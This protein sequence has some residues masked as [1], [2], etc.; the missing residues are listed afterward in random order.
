VSRVVRSAVELRGSGGWVS[1]KCP[2][3]TVPL[4]GGA[5]TNNPAY[6][7]SENGPGADGQSWMVS[8]AP[9]TQT[10]DATVGA[11]AVCGQAPG[12]EIVRAPQKA[13][14]TCPLGK[15]AIGGGGRF[16][17][18]TG[19]Y[20]HA[21][22]SSW[23]M[24]GGQGVAEAT[25]VICTTYPFVSVSTATAKRGAGL[26]Q[27][28][29]PTATCPAGQVLIGGGAST[30]DVGY[31]A[32]SGSAPGDGNVFNPGDN[33]QWSVG[34]TVYSLWAKTEEKSAQAQAICVPAL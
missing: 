27:V 13:M 12:Y 22:G 6:G 14:A 34:F 23:V 5:L 33:K 26:G 21:N 4:S 18:M 30:S 15:Q 29:Y 9:L 10:R 31:L 8:Y 7:I 24:A 11:Y 3:G 17:Q 1:V 25:S 2:A 19:S 16:A 20:R 28:V 32:M